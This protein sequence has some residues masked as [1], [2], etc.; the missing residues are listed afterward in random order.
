MSATFKL[1]VAAVLFA[2][3][4]AIQKSSSTESQVFIDRNGDRWPEYAQFKVT[5]TSSK[6]VMFFN[7]VEDKDH[8]F[9]YNAK[10]ATS[11]TVYQRTTTDVRLCDS[12]FT[13]YEF[14]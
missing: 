13:P 8:F 14:R 10:R 2:V 9:K 7:T 4:D 11:F 12:I 3:G 6:E 1:G 5:T